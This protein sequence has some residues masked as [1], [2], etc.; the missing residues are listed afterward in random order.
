LHAIDVK[1]VQATR[2]GAM[3]PSSAMPDELIPAQARAEQA[4]WHYSPALGGVERIEGTVGESEFPRHSHPTYALGVVERGV[5]RNYFRGAWH[6]VAPGMICTVTPGETHAGV[7]A[8]GAGFTYRCLYPTATQL[9]GASGIDPDG[10]PRGT[11][12]LPAAIDDA[13][14]ATSLRLLFA[15]VAR[16]A[17][18]LEEETLLAGCLAL[19]ARHGRGRPA[20]TAR[21]PRAR[22][23]VE[24]ARELLAARLVD[25]P[26]LAE[27]ATAV[28]LHPFALLRQFQRAVGLPP[29]AFVVQLRVER[30]RDLL[31]AGR[32]PAAVAA[33]L[34]FADQAHLTRQFKQRI[35]VPPGAYARAFRTSR[36]RNR[37]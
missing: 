6:D 10:S 4:R 37:S 9:D 1:N 35:G 3:L 11:L 28:G 7:S 20:P 19:A 36:P 33:A 23:A 32:S 22:R 12:L 2:R 5:N 25:P 16:V 31:R 14:L 21:S 18:L 8:G 13:E 17:P 29:H 15:A 26:A 24:Q 34:G 30:A 27:L